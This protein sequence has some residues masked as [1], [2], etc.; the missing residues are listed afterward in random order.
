MGSWHLSQD[1]EDGTEQT[2]GKG[3]GNS[4]PGGR[5]T[6]QRLGREKG[7]RVGAR[8]E[9][10]AVGSLQGF[11]FANQ[12]DSQPGPRRVSGRLFTMEAAQKCSNGVSLGQWGSR[13]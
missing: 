5:T 4:I 11:G 9:Q 2:T 6:K 13:G 3:G 1:Q 8:R 10:K 12:L 7:W